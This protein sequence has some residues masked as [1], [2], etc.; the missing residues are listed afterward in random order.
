[1]IDKQIGCVEFISDTIPLEILAHALSFPWIVL[2]FIFQQCFDDRVNTVVKG[3]CYEITLNK[4]N[5]TN[6]EQNDHSDFTG[7]KNIFLLFNKMKRKK[8]SQ[9]K[10]IT[11]DHINN[12]IKSKGKSYHRKRKYNRIECKLNN[13]IEKR[14]N[15]T[16]FCLC[17]VCFFH[18]GRW[19]NAGRSLVTEIYFQERQY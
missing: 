17:S 2:V 10:H 16:S 6:G 5:R 8:N 4:G 11:L 9:T 19:L 13:F 3:V 14:S 12:T 18:N 15:L 1:M 7:S